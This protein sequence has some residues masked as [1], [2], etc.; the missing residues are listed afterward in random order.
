MDQSVTVTTGSTMSNSR[1]DG[2]VEEVGRE[3]STTAS[4]SLSVCV[5]TG[6]AS[7]VSVQGCATTGLERTASRSVRES[8]STEA[9][10]SLEESSE[11]THTFSPRRAGLA[12][13]QFRIYSHEDSCGTDVTTKLAQFTWTESKYDP[14]VCTPSGCATEDDPWGRCC[15]CT[16]EEDRLPGAVTPASCPQAEPTLLEQ[17]QAKQTEIRS[18]QEVIVSTGDSCSNIWSI[19]ASLDNIEGL[20]RDIQHSSGPVRI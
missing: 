7:P 13:W 12:L 16:H 20:L 1:A 8:L 9:A 10:W 17:I 18:A 14:P 6:D 11:T 4:E 5:G 19:A 15:S 3:L 2:T